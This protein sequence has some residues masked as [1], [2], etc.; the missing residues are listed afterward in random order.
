[1]RSIAGKMKSYSYDLLLPSEESAYQYEVESIKDDDHESSVAAT[2][3]F[4]NLQATSTTTSLTPTQ[5]SLTRQH[6]FD[7]LFFSR[8]TRL[9]RILFLPLSARRGLFWFYLVFLSLCTLTEFIYYFVGLLPSKFYKILLSENSGDFKLL[10]LESLVL[11]GLAGSA[12]AVVSY[13]CG[14]FSLKIRRILTVY[15][16]NLYIQPGTLY[17]LALLHESRVDNPDQRITQDIDKFA[18]CIGKISEELSVT[19]LLIIYYTYKCWAVGGIFGPLFIYLYFIIGSIVSKLLIAPVVPCVFAKELQEGGFRYMHVRLRVFAESI[20]FSRGEREEKIRAEQNL[21]GLLGTQQKIL[22][23]ELALKLAN[24]TFSY[25]GSILS[26]LIISIAIFSGA[27]SG[28]DK[29]ELSSIISLNSFISMYLIHRFTEIL[30]QSARISELAG[31]TARLGQLLEALSEI[32]SE[33]DNLN[34]DFP[35]RDDAGRANDV[36]IR[37]DGVSITAPNGK[38]LFSNLNLN[39]KKGENVMIVGNNG[40][41]KTSLLRV[42][43]GIW[44]SSRGR[45]ALPRREG[46]REPILFLPQTS[47]LV[48]GSLRDQIT[49][50]SI[51]AADAVPDEEVDRLLNLVNL[52]HLSEMVESYDTAYGQEWSKMLSPG[53][54]QRLSFARIFFWKPI[55]AVLDEATSAMDPRI[56]SYLYNRL[57]HF[58]IT[59]ISVSHN[60]HLL[61]HHDRVII[62]GNGRA[63]ECIVDKDQ[64][65]ALRL[66]ILEALEGREE[67]DEGEGSGQ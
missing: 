31:Y 67:E 66:V 63:R 33:L 37:F 32:H 50:P 58:G 19:P 27:Y 38:P 36:E 42:M 4:Q 46:T 39:I 49:Y 11:V 48:F 65:D 55:F 23:R 41:G 3:S 30:R 54:Q 35:Y 18:E 20:S 26:Y 15:F 7:S 5:S 28:I 45:V 44:P 56:E 43:S 53:E 25:F 24:E 29:G 10:V 17:K 22:D 51:L 52:S 62:L 21:M 6:G 12:K 47:Y 8:F 1:M 60:T 16:Q 61:R 34:I 40:C 13:M 9:L 59:C 57:K 64:L 2:A 14:L